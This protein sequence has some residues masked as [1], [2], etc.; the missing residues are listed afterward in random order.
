M[1]A[2]VERGSQVSGSDG[3]RDL[4]AAGWA[5][6]VPGLFEDLVAQIFAPLCGKRVT[7]EAAEPG[8]ERR[9]YASIEPALMRFFALPR[10]FEPD[11]SMCE[12]SISKVSAL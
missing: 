6:F 2:P 5:V 8:V 12:A 4:A 1:L 9:D 10:R 7:G 11:S 3:R